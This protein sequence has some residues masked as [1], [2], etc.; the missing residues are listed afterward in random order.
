[1]NSKDLDRYFGPAVKNL[2][3][4]H[5]AKLHD[6]NTDYGRGSAGWPAFVRLDILLGST[7]YRDYYKNPHDLDQPISEEFKILLQALAGPHG[8][9]ILK[10]YRIKRGLE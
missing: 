2:F 9:T 6:W 7:E 1:M 8:K 10:A 3:E 4:D 5:N